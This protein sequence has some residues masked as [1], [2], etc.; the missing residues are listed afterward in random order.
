MT[1][2]AVPTRPGPFTRLTLRTAR[3]KTAALTGR[4]T[5]QMIEPLEAYAHS[6]GLLMGYGALEMANARAGR[7]DHRLKELTALKAATIVECEYCIDIGSS[8]GRRVG[9]TDEQLLAL[10]RHR[11]SGLFS[12]AEVLALDLADAMTR[13][14]VRV[15]EE[16][17]SALRD[18]FDEG[19]LVELVANIALENMRSRFNAALD[20]G[21]A[22]L[23]EGMVCAIPASAAGSGVADA[24]PAA[25]APL[26]VSA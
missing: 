13:T 5:A 20:I 19:Q 8:I 12:E 15:S 18:H 10:S 3:K 1:R 26:P 14:P 25:S 2:I 23:S 9:V 6:P 22:G 24:Q 21:S 7:I 4:E 11:E 16:L 17:Y